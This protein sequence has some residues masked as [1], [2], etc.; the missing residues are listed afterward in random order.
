MLLKAADPSLDKSVA[1]SPSG[2]TIV[3]QYPSKQGTTTNQSQQPHYL[4]VK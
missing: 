3:M 2:A 1:K 4:K